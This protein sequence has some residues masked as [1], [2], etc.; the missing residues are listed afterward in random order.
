MYVYGLVVAAVDIKK[1][2]KWVFVILINQLLKYIVIWFY[3][4]IQDIGR[5]RICYFFSNAY[6][7]NLGTEI[8]VAES[9][10]YQNDWQVARTG[11]QLN[12]QLTYR[13]DGFR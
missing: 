10:V 8:I 2:I 5:V 13:D 7:N 3:I 4:L 11:I 12:N 6:T 1:A 9:T